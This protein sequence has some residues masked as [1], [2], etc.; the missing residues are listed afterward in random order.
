MYNIISVSA[1]ERKIL[2]RSWFF[3]IF[4]SIALI[5]LI[6]INILFFGNH[7]GAHWSTRAIPANLPYIN[8]LF[9]NIAQAVIAIFMASEFLR[10]DKK[11]DTTEVIYTRPVSNAEYVVGKTLGILSLFAV[12]VLMSLIITLVFNLVK[13]D[14]PVTWEA[15][16]YY[17]LLIALPTL[18]YIL[19]LSFFLMILFKNQA[20]TFLI[21][22][23]YIG[24]T[25]FYFKGKQNGLLDYT[26]LNL[27][28]VY[29]D[30]I[31]FSDLHKILLHRLAYL[32]MGIG[33]IFATIR[34]IN[35]LPQIGRWNSINLIAFFLFLSAGI[36][37]GYRYHEIYRTEKQNRIQYLALNNQ[38][39]GKPVADIISNNIVLIQHDNYLSLS[40]ELVISNP[41]NQKMD[42]LILSLNPGFNIDSITARHENVDYFTTGHIIQ[43]LPENGLEPGRRF[44]IKIYYTGLPDESIAYSDIPEEQRASLKSIQVAKLNK[45][46]GIVS[47]DFLLLTQE[48]LWY[49]VAGTGFNTE[50]F[51]PYK[52]DF[53]R[54]RLTVTPRGKLIPVAPGRMEKEEGTYHFFPETDLPSFALIA[55]PFIIK[56]MELDGIEY[57]I[58]LKSG[59]DFFSGY[60]INIADT[61]SAIIKE[62][63]DN[64]ERGVLDLYYPFKRLNIV[65]VPIQYHAYER[66]YMQSIS[67]LQPE[68]ILIPERGAGLSSLDF[69][70]YALFE[71]RTTRR[72]ESTRSQV[73]IETD[74]FRRFL[75]VTFFSDNIRMRSTQGNSM[76]QGMELIDFQGESRYTRNPYCAF[77]FYYSFVTG[78][79]S[80]EYPLFNSMV[81][82]YL[83]EGFEVL[84]GQ[85]FSGGLTDTERANLALKQYSIPE[86]LKQRNPNLTSALIKQAGA[87]IILA[88]KNSVGSGD[89]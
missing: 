24:L 12:L 49:P 83:K 69:N 18:V 23:G 30:F 60:F 13:K 75:Q 29:S 85:S 42:T 28:M 27:P 2:F 17:P 33:F 54:F 80:D 72:R 46:A 61:L 44:R 65:E 52:P 37:L 1:Y 59:H 79:T 22:L 50:R 41:C 86:I 47:R 20:V 38:F 45:K 11:L 51:L 39:A 87:F 16:L 56:E 57:S 15:Y 19:G 43:I 4:A 48:L 63:K 6:I 67:V 74:L 25:L 35:R 88:L 62:E 3:R 81:E 21:L 78:I 36:F 55:G 53:V 68:M 64:Y 76:A 10:R 31:Q 71:S 58:F 34:F 73:E 89:F 70:R 5:L 9:I 7:I 14:T 40:S 32:F 77:P 8:V 84:P 82:V 66:P 26:A